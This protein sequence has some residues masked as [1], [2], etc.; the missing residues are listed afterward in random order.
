MD[1]IS[2]VSSISGLGLFATRRIG[3][4]CLI[5]EELPL[6]VEK[7]P[8]DPNFPKVWSLTDQAAAMGLPHPIIMELSAH[9]PMSDEAMGW[10]SSDE[11]ALHV[12]STTRRLPRR[13]V[14]HLYSVL[15]AINLMTGDQRHAVYAKAS[16]LNHACTPNATCDF[17]GSTLR[18]RALK[19]LEPHEEITIKYV[20]FS[21]PA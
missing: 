2:G 10:D 12:L 19:Q 6:I 7:Q 1:L 8:S 15:C 14:K 4:N 13:K 20:H 17:S 16:Y 9:P 11:T 18:L 3:K 21:Y 5:M